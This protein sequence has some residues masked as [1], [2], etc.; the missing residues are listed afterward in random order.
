MKRFALLAIIFV[1]CC[2]S[3]FAQQAKTYTWNNT[4]FSFQVPVPVQ[5]KE[6]TE[7]SYEVDGDGLAVNIQL[8]EDPDTNIVAI[9]KTVKDI[10]GDI[11]I[12]DI[13]SP[14]NLKMKPGLLG[15]FIEGALDDANANMAVILDSK[16]K[17]EICVTI[18]FD[19]GMEDVAT[20]ILSSF[21]KK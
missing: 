13:S 5:V 7:T 21:I 1:A 17:T 11:G 3:L 14:V 20:R 4:R 12:T 6:D 2:A 15:A 18:V 10:A 16:S 8:L 19:D 9:R